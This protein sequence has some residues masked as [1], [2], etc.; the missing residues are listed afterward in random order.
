ME[1]PAQILTLVT[2]LGKGYGIDIG[3][4]PFYFP[5]ATRPP[6]EGYFAR[7][8]S[9]YVPAVLQNLHRLLNSFH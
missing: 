7:N 1:L 5:H 4:H 9:A 8:Y 6:W 3:G 2:V